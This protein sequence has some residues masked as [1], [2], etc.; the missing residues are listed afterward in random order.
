[1]LGLVR[2]RAVAQ[3][4]LLAA[5]LAVLLPAL[6]LVALIRLHGT[7]AERDGVRKAL[8][9]L[10]D[11]ARSVT[12]VYN[13]GSR[14]PS[15]PTSRAAFLADVEQH[16][17]QAFDGVDTAIL[18][19]S[20][21]APYG[22][23]GT[24]PAY[25]VYFL[26]SVVS[27][28]HAQLLAGAWPTALPSTAQPGTR[29]TPGT[30]FEAAIPEAAA[31]ANNWTIGTEI[32][33]SARMDGVKERV[34]ITG[35]YRPTD[36]TDAF[37]QAESYKGA[38]KG[39]EDQ[40]TFGPLLVDPSVTA[41]AKLEIRQE[42]MIASPDFTT[43]QTKAA[44]TLQD[45]LA[46]LDAWLPQAA[47]GVDPDIHATVGDRLAPRTQGIDADLRI[48]SRLNL[49][50]VVELS[51]LALTALVLTTRLL[52]EHRRESDGLLRARGASVRGL[53]RIGLAEGLLLTVPTAAVAPSWRASSNAAST[54]AI[55]PPPATTP[56]RSPRTCG[57]W[58][59]SAR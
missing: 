20:A 4:M 1:M 17:R 46:P 8:S 35:I 10:P 32:P 31:K 9:T 48:S 25:S 45:R 11:S 52:S 39:Q 22:V 5:A 12:A 16:M 43:I 19:E 40:P 24:K 50:P 36:K 57:S 28:T 26:G 27:P 51:L 49:L 7:T 58:W 53:L 34:K 33:L 37:W 2:K 44:A 3:R 29:T 55:G 42:S 41:G 23:D 30:E 18:H 47:A 15:D 38:G 6:V 56:P 14:F 13:I 21:S 54:P 59:R